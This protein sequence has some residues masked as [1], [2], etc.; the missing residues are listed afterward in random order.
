MAKQGKTTKNMDAVDLL[1]SQHRE[2]E[3][4]FEEFADATGNQKKRAIF[5]QIADK[6]AV[7][8]GIEEKDFYPSVKAEETEDL[9]L[10]SLEEHLA[11]K[12]VIADLLA[13]DPSDETFEAKVT[14][15]Q[16]QIEH[17]VE[18][19]EEELFPKVRKLFDSEVLQALAQQMIATQEELLQEENPRDSVLGE[20]SEAPS[21]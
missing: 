6:L 21:L 13:M 18:E 11:A 8:A 15:L 14:V 1:K 4:L 16:E 17:H 3:D 5:E 2:V 12:R 10:E 19:E 20:T 7:H 9:L